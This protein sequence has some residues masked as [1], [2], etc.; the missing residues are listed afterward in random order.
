MRSSLL[1]KIGTIA[2]LSA[3]ALLLSG[4]PNHYHH[5]YEPIVPN[6]LVLENHASS[7]GDILYAYVSPST[8]GIWGSDRLGRNVLNPGDQLVMNV[9]DC[10]HHYDIMVEYD[11]GLTVVEPDQWLPCNTTTIVSFVDYYGF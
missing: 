5:H 1:K 6:T 2:V 3:T 7:F 10:N 11:N 9:Y 8:S 4:C